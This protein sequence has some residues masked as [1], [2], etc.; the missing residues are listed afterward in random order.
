MMEQVVGEIIKALMDDEIRGGKSDYIRE[1]RWKAEQLEWHF[2]DKYPDKLLHAQ[3]PSEEAWM[4]DYRRHRWQPPTKTSTGRVYNFLQKIQQADDFKIRWETD[5]TKTGIAERVGN[6]DNTLKSYVTSGMPRIPNLETWTFNLFLKTYLQDANS[7]VV[8]LPRFDEFVKNPRETPTLDFS[9]PYPQIIETDDLLYEEE[10]WVL[11][12]VEEWKDANGHEWCQYMAVTKFGLLLFRQYKEIREIDPFEVYFI[13]FDFPR[14]PVI[15]TG[16]VIY[17]EEDGHLIYD[18][19]LAPCLP[20]WNEVL[21]RTDDLNILYAVHAL[22][23]KWALK[24][25][26][27]K[28]CNGTGEAYNHKHEKV[29]CGKCSGSGRASTS[30]FGL[31]EINI[32]RVSAINP[33]PTIPPIPPAGYIER[34]TDAVKLFQEDIMYKEF[35]GLK[36]IGLEILGQIPGNQS[37]IAKEYDRKELNTFCFSVC[38]HLVD[39]YERVCFH[40]MG[41]RYKSLFDSGLMTEE[42]VMNALP[43]VTIPT[44]FDVLTSSAISTMLS[45]ARK[46]AYN[47]IIVHG[48]ESDYVEKLYGENSPQKY[49]LKVNNA[50]DPLPFKT[51]DEKVMLVAQGGCTKRDFVLSANLTSFIMQLTEAN[52]EWVKK[53]LEEQRKDVDALADA[54][55]AEINS[56]LVPLMPEG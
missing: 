3:H 26:P 33:N 42:K 51:T 30:P 38:V 8:V 9:R 20:A 37:G 50:L 53:S 35:Q 46:S 48:L 40:I 24:L 31:L 14:L 4:R 54:K 5:Y 41:Q 44:D 32:D 56:G 6:I 1:A 11:F 47:P 36:A 52:P 16:N 45:E 21:Y 55:L 2:E 19:V 12:E 27:C 7:I 10:E 25:S 23:Q 49:F 29:S 34:P 17:E 13:A 22:P 39:V 15:K 18:S 43:K 28:T